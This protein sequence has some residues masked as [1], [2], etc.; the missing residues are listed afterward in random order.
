MARLAPL[1]AAVAFGFVGLVAAPSP[2]ASAEGVTL[3]ELGILTLFIRCSGFGLP[4]TPRP[5]PG[6]RNHRSTDRL[7]RGRRAGD[8]GRSSDWRI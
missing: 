1:F 8:L 6:R 2:Q 4:T 3:A 7:R 5:I